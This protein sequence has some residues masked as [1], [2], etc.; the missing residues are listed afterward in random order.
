MVSE[1]IHRNLRWAE[2]VHYQTYD[3]YD[4]WGTRIGGKVKKLYTKNAL[5]GAP[6]LMPFIIADMVWPNIRM[7]FSEK[8]YFEISLAHTGLA[9]LNIFD[10]SGDEGYLAK[11]EELVAPLLGMATKCEHGPGWGINLN[12][13]SSRETIPPRS[14]CLTQTSYVYEFLKRLYEKTHKSHYINYIQSIMKH[15]A[16]D[17]HEWRKDDR[18]SCCYF[19]HEKTNIAVVNSN[20]YRAMN[21]IDAGKFFD[22][23]EYLEKGLSTLRFIL[24]MQNRDGSWPYSE[25]QDF[26]DHYHTCFVLK[27]L[28]KIGTI[29]SGEY[30]DLQRALENGLHYYFARL[31][32]K[33]GYPV[34][35]SVKPRS[36]LHKYDAY[37]F[38]EAI[39]LLSEMKIEQERM[40]KLCLFVCDRFQTKAG[41][42]KFRLYPVNFGDGI[43]Y[44]RYANSAMLLALTNVLR[45]TGGAYGAAD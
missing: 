25:T 21:L 39:S 42:F 35:F 5:M 15:I 45:N 31:Y 33:E 36:V 20:S 34:P 44:I 27:N 1:M 24:F 37:D 22:N 10:V 41:W 38:A 43:P 32:N 23:Q 29:M 16:F 2:Q 14:P 26:V 13:T 11:A 4:I 28:N 3:W 17:Y 7:L 6:F 40:I 19:A 9:Y 12:W 8:R 18:L 30:P